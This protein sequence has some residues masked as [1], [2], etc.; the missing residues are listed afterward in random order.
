MELVWEEYF[1][2]HFRMTASGFYY[3]IHGLINQQVNAA[4][5]NAVFVN[6]GALDLRGFEFSLSR[7]LPRGMEGTATYSYQDAT[8]TSTRLAVTNAPRHLAQA[9]LSIP[10]AKQKVF[11]SMDLQY[12]S[13]R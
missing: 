11:A 12:V 7:S 6:A 10:L 9:S 13:K 3:P 1:A 4:T 5:G 8:N 2:N